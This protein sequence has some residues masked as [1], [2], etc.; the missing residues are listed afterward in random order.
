MPLHTFT[1]VRDLGPGIYAVS[2]GLY[3]Y[4]ASNPQVVEGAHAQRLD[5]Y[6]LAQIRSDL[7]LLVVRTVNGGCSSLRPW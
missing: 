6:H 5:T 7:P 3:W 1:R 4:Q 2:V